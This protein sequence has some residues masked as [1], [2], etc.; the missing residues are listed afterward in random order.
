MAASATEQLGLASSL[1]SLIS[2]LLADMHTRSFYTLVTLFNC[3]SGA[4]AA[5]VQLSNLKLPSSAASHKAAVDQLLTRSWYYYKRVQ[6][7]GLPSTPVNTIIR[8][9]AFG[10]DDL[11]PLSNGSSDPLGGWGASIVDAMD[12][13]LIAG[14]TSLFNECLTYVQDLD[15]STA[16][17]GDDISVFETTIRFVGGFISAYELSG[18]KYPILIEKAKEVADKLFYGYVG[19]RDLSSPSKVIADSPIGQRA[20][21]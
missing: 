12:T 7:S 15:F 8:K 18:K 9:N 20:T 4:L 14:H 11:S 5:S 2:F 3:L 13:F 1:F 6:S 21:I 10:H 17:T 16:P 19:V